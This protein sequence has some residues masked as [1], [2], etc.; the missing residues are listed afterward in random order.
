MYDIVL[1]SNMVPQLDGLLLILLTAVFYLSDA[2]FIGAYL[3]VIRFCR[4]RLIE[5]YPIKSRCLPSNTSG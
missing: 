3:L 4:R 2:S 1:A 5:A